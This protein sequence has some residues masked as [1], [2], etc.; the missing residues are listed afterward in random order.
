MRD[1]H[2]VPPDAWYRVPMSW[3]FRYRGIT[4][5]KIDHAVHLFPEQGFSRRLCIS[6][7][8]LCV[9]LVLA[10]GCQSVGPGTVTRDRDDYSASISDS[11]KRQMLLNIVKLRYL[12]PPIFVDVGQIVAG[13]SLQTVLSAGA[14]FPQNGAVGGNTATVGGGATYTDRPTITYTPL[15][16]D[17]FLKA[18]MT[19]LPPE[20]VFYTIESGWPADAILFTCVARLNALRNQTASVGGLNPADPRFLKA[21][22]LLRRIQDSGAVGM[23]VVH[24]TNGQE[25]VLATFGSTDISEQ[26]R[27]AG[28]ELRQLLGLAPQANE[29]KLVYGT[30]AAD[31]RELAMQTRSLLHILGVLAAQVEVPPEHVAEGRAAPGVREAEQGG[32]HVVPLVRIH[33]S[34]DKPKDAYVAV[35]Y[36]DHWFWIDACD[37]KSKRAFAFMLLLFTLSDT[38]EQPGPALITIPAQ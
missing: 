26:A 5:V 16:G 10:T 30:V 35:Q 8:L 34:K 13:Y 37:L 12:D 7:S 3:C 15:T 4:P 9:A 20:A 38:G 21:L 22:E 11:W 36:Q 25:S 31:D 27:A 28:Q 1:C 29:F 17:K 24:G 33:G 14:S 18:L 2:G 32:V 6:S 19:P 23:R